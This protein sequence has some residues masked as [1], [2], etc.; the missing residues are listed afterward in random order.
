MSKDIIESTIDNGMGP[1]F[2]GLSGNEMYCAHLLGY[3]PGNLL[4]GNSVFSMGL[5]GSIGSSIKTVVG[6][7]IHQYTNMIAEGRRLSLE[8]FA[9]ELEQSED[10]GATGVTSE[11]IFHPGNVEFLTVGSSIHTE[12]SNTGPS[13]TTSANAQELFCQ[14]DAGY[15]PKSFVFG[16]VAYSIGIGKSFL[17]S[18]KELVK[19]EVTQYSGIFNTTRNLALQRI[20]SEAQ[21]KGANSVVGIRTS[22]IPLGSKGVQEMVMIGTASHN[23]EFGDI[24]DS[25]GGVTTSDLTAE[26]TWNV[27]KMGYV[28]MKLILGTSVYSLGFAGGVMSSLRNLVKGE[29]KEMTELIYGAR[30]QS[31]MKVKQ[32]ANEIG[33]DDVLG[34]KTYVYN[35]GSGVIEFLAIGTA[36]KRV[37]GVTTRSDQIPPQAIISDKDTFIDTANISYGVDLQNP[38]NKR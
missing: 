22:I 20:Q 36:V 2:S 8:R 5:M 31:L 6:G 30:E 13:F 7:E 16:N 28:P 33:A 9:A 21:D 35:L 19:G 18:F 27:A 4:V 3:K 25:V 34:I 12:T 29:I 24:A 38:N 14:W 26:E 32:Q 23:S 15:T 11:L 17:G 37:S 1:R 10:E